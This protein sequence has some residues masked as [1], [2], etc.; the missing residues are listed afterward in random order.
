[1]T[2]SIYSV[3]GSKLVGLT[4]LTGA[5][6]ALR[7]FARWSTPDLLEQR[8]TESPGLPQPDPGSLP[9]VTGATLGVP[10]LYPRRAAIAEL[11]VPHGWPVTHPRLNAQALTEFGSWL[12]A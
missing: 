8:D 3:D 12:S 7:H 2:W 9:A 1:M 11:Q 5:V 6:R 4:G 10:I